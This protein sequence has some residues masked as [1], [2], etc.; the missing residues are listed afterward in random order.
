M[1]SKH[2]VHGLT[3]CATRG[4]HTEETLSGWFGYD[5]DRIAALRKHE[6]I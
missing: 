1:A 2:A 5:W 4:Q 3:Q 6:I